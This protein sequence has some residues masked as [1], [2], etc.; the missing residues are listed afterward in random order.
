MLENVV[1][2]SENSQRIALYKSYLLLLLFIIIIIK[3]V[4]LIPT[5]GSAVKRT[6]KQAGGEWFNCWTFLV[7]FAWDEEV[8]TSTTHSGRCLCVQHTLMPCWTPSLT[9]LSWR[10]THS[11]WRFL[12]R[13][14]RV[15]WVVLSVLLDWWSCYPPP[16]PTPRSCQIQIRLIAEVSNHSFVK[17][18]PDLQ[19]LSC[20]LLFTYTC[21]YGDEQHGVPVFLWGVSNTLELKRCMGWCKKNSSLIHKQLG[22][23]FMQTWP[24]KTMAIYSRLFQD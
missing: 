16:H 8:S 18:V 20:R 12:Q 6:T 23:S 7:I 4:K 10:S 17:N 2:R 15:M 22:L 21:T 1:K 11:N 3:R 24:C 19:I 13:T 14:L 5:N 9:S